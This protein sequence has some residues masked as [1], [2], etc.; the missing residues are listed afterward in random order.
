MTFTDYVK[1]GTESNPFS[2]SYTFT[3]TKLPEIG[4]TIEVIL[5]D[6]SY[7]PYTH[8]TAYNQDIKLNNEITYVRD[9][10]KVRGTIPKNTTSRGTI[11][12][13]VDEYYNDC[14]YDFKNALITGKYSLFDPE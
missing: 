7:V 10:T 6:D 14:E 12:G 11:Y 5:G 1:S 3:L 4:D 8:I 9:Y 2:E 13:M